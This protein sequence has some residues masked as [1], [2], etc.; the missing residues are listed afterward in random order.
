MSE[1]KLLTEFLLLYKEFPCLWDNRQVLYTNK[2]ARDQAYEVLLE[3]YKQI[4]EDAN[5]MDVKKK[6]EHMRCCYRR[7][8]KKVSIISIQRIFVGLDYQ[9]LSFFT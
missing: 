7:E 6:I 2:E 1:K 9:T 5:I 4:Q 8:H 3:K